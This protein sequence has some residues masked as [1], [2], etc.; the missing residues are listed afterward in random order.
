M[1]II[2]YQSFFNNNDYECAWKNY[3]NLIIDIIKMKIKSKD[4]N[5][6]E[7][8]GGR[9][10]LLTDSDINSIGHVTYTV[11]DISQD[12]LDRAP[13]C[14][15]KERFDISSNIPA[16]NFAKYDVVFMK[17]VME[18]VKNGRIVYE[19]ILSLLS[20]GG[21]FINFHPTLFSPP[22]LINLLM[23]ETISRKI[24]KIFLPHRNDNEYPKFPAYYKY[25]YSTDNNRKKIKDIGFSEVL[26]VPFYGHGYYFKKIPL[27]REIDQ[28]ITNFAKNRNFRLLSSFAIT[29]VKK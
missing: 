12:E 13:N 11:N 7:I 27:V 2:K 17:M 8:G 6:L 18:H 26:I 16:R 21:V 1:G 19:N 22:F 10:P 28:L 5:I 3:K 15:N 9:F 24:L 29:I 25:C 20:S 23:P 4:I 14:F